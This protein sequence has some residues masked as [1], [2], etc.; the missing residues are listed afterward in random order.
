MSFIVSYDNCREPLKSREYKGKNLIKLPLDFVILDLETTGLDPQLDNIIE[1]AAIRVRNGAIADSYSSLIHIDGELDEFITELTGITNDMLENAP[2]LNNVLTQARSFIGDDIVIGYNVNFDVNFLYEAYEAIGD[3]HF[4]NNFIDVLRFSR[5]LFP[6]MKHHRLKDMIE[7]LNISCT[8]SHRAMA[9]CYTTLECYFKLRDLALEKYSSEEQFAA[10]WKHFQ[11]NYKISSIKSNKD[12]FDETHPLY[13]KICVFTGKL[14]S[15]TRA[16]AA[17]AVVDVGGIC[18]DAVTKETN[19][20]ILGNND[21]CSSIKD[22]KSN[23]QKKAESYK[24]KGCEIDIISEKVFFD[25][26]SHNE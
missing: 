21:Y 19:Y 18:G 26:I 1:F 24:L 16:Q 11:G 4:N 22:G 25:L 2:T 8:D 23:K 9:D 20:L 5:R 10:T 7:V 3:I 15:V 6:E 14:D 13:N 17:Q 12:A